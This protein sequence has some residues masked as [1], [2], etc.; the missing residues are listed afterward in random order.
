MKPLLPNG[1]YSLTNLAYYNFSLTKMLLRHIIMVLKIGLDRCWCPFTWHILYKPVSTKLDFLVGSIHVFYSF[2]YSPSP[3]DLLGKLRKCGL[4]GM[5]W[6]LLDLLHEPSP[7]V[8][9]IGQGTLVAPLAH[10]GGLVL[11]IFTPK[12]LLCSS[13]LWPKV[14]ARTLF[15]FKN[16]WLSLANFSY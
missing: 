11:V 3:C 5:G 1:L 12:Q 7:C 2:K 8:L 14:F 15:S 13:W 10:R 16:G 9:P 6:F 4:E